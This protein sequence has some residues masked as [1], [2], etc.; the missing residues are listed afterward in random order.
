[1]KKFM[2]NPVGNVVMM[3][4]GLVMI[5]AYLPQILIIIAAVALLVVFWRLSSPDRGQSSATF[6][7]QC[8]HAAHGRRWCQSCR[9]RQ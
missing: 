4:V 5:A 9:C 1:M 7:A 2:E 3:I 6:C 8:G